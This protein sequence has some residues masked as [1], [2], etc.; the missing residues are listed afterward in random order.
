M[1]FMFK[2]MINMTNTL[3]S[4][5]IVTNIEQISCIYVTYKMFIRSYLL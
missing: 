4:Y 1:S 5:D 2:T 3:Y